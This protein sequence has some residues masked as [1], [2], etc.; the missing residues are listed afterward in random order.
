MSI[1]LP[2]PMIALIIFSRRKDILGELCIGPL[3]RTLSIIGVI[4]VLSLNLV[5]L[6]QIVGL[7][8][9]GLL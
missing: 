4:V 6:A 7:A 2:V 5:F 3:L 1:A 9:P 8:I